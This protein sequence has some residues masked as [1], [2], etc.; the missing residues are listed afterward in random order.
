M[1]HT[2]ADILVVEDEAI[3][4]NIITWRM[5]GT[6]YKIRFAVTGQEA[7]D[8][9]AVKKPDLILL[10]VMLPEI[11]GL[12]V[13]HT[14][15]Q[16][17]SMV[18]LPVIMVTGI[19][20]NERI[21]RALELGANDYVTK[22]INFPILLARMQTQLSLKQ[23]AAMNTEFLATASHDLRKSLAKIAST[24][25]Q[26]RLKLA[27][28]NVNPQQ[29]LDD[30]TLISQSALQISNITSCVLDMQTSGFAQIRLTKTPVQM[31]QL[32]EESM[33]SQRDTVRHKQLQLVGPQHSQRLVVE[34][35][36]NRI[37]QVLDH[38]I[39]NAII[40]TA[41]GG[42]IR[43]NLLLANEQVRVE[44]IDDGA[45][46]REEFMPMLLQDN[47]LDLARNF[48]NLALCKQLIE[49]HQG[50]LGVMA[51]DA[52]KGTTFWFSLPLFKLRTVE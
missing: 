37:R 5:Q 3:N 44:V 31:E 29:L 26:S 13:L 17:Y 49:L 27:S 25:N 52:G 9:V 48:D 46:L 45:G 30:F 47:E 41:P 38:L 36:R 43:V 20:E 34:A 4:R 23:L 22:P 6:N 33:A 18:D 42:C 32:V 19:D 51:Q 24:A 16:S 39:E 21:V 11:M 14:L 35:D 8:Q 50:E 28:G 12:Q 1:L 40:S 2:I 7:L 15:R 10:D